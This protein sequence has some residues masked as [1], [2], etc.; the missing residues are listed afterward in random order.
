MRALNLYMLS[1]EIGQ[2]DYS[3]YESA[4]SDRVELQ[5]MKKYEYESLKSLVMNLL[6]YQ[7]SMVELDGFFWSF[8]INQIG[9]EFDLL[10]ISKGNY[11]IDIELKS[12]TV[13]EEKIEKQLL[14]NEYYL[15]CLGKDTFLYTYVQETGLIYTLFN[16][17]LVQSNI[18]ALVDSIKKMAGEYETENIDAMFKATDFL[19]SPLN[20]PERFIEGQYFLTNQQEEIK[21]NILRDISNG[22]KKIWGISGSAG[23]GKT[24][25]LYDIIRELCKTGKC[26]VIHSGIL[27][28]GHQMLSSAISNLYIYDAKSVNILNLH[29]YDYFFV[30]ETQRLYDSTFQKLLD[31]QKSFQKVCIFSYDSFQTLSHKEEERK[32]AMKLEN[33]KGFVGYKLTDKIRSNQEI[34]SFIKNMLNLN[35]IPRKK[36][37]Y[38]NIDVVYAP[39]VQ[40]ANAI[41]EFYRLAKDY[42]FIDYTKSIF[43]RNSIDEY[44]GDIDTHHVIGQEFDNVLF[45]MDGNFRYG[46]DG[47]LQ[48]YTH[49]NPDYRFYKLLYQGISRAREKLCILVVENEKLFQDLLNI[50]LS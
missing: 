24:L 42:V 17:K 10:K 40:E 18:L 23:T 30:D 37:F 22:E 2:A 44:H 45:V 6:N 48:A 15:K 36:L 19:I 8:K 50:R 28:D 47:H 21:R 49:P 12:N 5:Q 46:E 27:C 31:M 16:G 4:L 39:N 34:A 25:L 41:I 7:L 11:A 20:T 35:D 26:C 14:Q 1:R 32:I 13:P 38:K 3:Q 29:N 9:K 33:E 43:Y